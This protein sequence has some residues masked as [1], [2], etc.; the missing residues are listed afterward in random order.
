MSIRYKDEF[1]NV[2]IHLYQ[3]KR[4]LKHKNDLGDLRMIM[5]AA[6]ASWRLGCDSS[7]TGW[8]TAS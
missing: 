1:D 6:E 7:Y 4:S 5:T 8:N 3:F 2:R